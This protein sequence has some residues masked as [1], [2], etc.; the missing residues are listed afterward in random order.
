[1]VYRDSRKGNKRNS[2]RRVFQL[3]YQRDKNAVM[4]NHVGIEAFLFIYYMHRVGGR[5]NKL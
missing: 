3:S 1:M 5:P 4:Y 2:A